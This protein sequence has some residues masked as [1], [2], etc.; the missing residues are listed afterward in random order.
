MT[1]TLLDL[2][3]HVGLENVTLQSLER[4]LRGLD[5]SKKQGC[6]IVRF[7]T[8]AIT[9]NDFVTDNPKRNVGFVLWIPKDKIPKAEEPPSPVVGEK[10]GF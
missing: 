9:P 2:I 3:N 4:D 8:N 1:F 10:E 6:T 7:G 5:S